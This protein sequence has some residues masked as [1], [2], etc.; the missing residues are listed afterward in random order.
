[1]KTAVAHGVFSIDLPSKLWVFP[2]RPF[3]RLGQGFGAYRVAKQSATNRGD[4][5]LAGKYHYAEGS[6]QCWNKLISGAQLL[7][8]F[9]R[10][11]KPI[12]GAWDA[13]W[14]VGE[15]LFGRLLFGYGERIRGILITAF[16]VIFGWASA[17]CIW[18]IQ[19]V[20]KSAE[21]ITYR[22]SW[23]H[24]FGGE[25][26]PVAKAVESGV[27]HNFWDSLYFSIVT[28]TTLG[29]GDMRPIGGMRVFAASEALIG[30]FLMALFVVA[31]ARKFTR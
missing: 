12:Q 31:M 18:G 14:A 19:T 8:P 4:Y 28:F 25:V 2:R 24:W 26:E 30:A 29:Y 22:W 3:K 1:M 13:F 9:S 10:P 23:T 20:G 11:R 15:F 16:L 5:T 6:I 27:T 7:W 21:A 17:Y